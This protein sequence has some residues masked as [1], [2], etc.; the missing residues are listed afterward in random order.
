MSNSVAS[1]VNTPEVVAAAVEATKTMTLKDLWRSAK[2]ELKERETGGD[3]LA[4]MITFGS[5]SARRAALLKHFIGVMSAEVDR[6]EDEE[7]RSHDDMWA[8]EQEVEHLVGLIDAA[9]LWLKTYQMRYPG[10]S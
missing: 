7:P 1:P 10:S 6:L 8:T 3:L 4:N 2:K 9:E 5:V